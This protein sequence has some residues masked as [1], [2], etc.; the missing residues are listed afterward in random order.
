MVQ[1]VIDPFINVRAMI[2]LLQKTLPERKDV[3][4]YMINNVRL[5]LRELDRT[6]F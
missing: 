4:I 2:E 1:M 6:M 5:K 3:D